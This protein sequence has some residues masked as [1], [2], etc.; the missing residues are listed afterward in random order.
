M[1]KGLKYWGKK[2]HNIWS[3]YILTYCQ[4]ND[5]VLDV[6]AGSGV[7]ALEAVQIGRRAISIDLNPMSK[8]IVE[9][10]VSDFN[11]ELFIKEGNEVCNKVYNYLKEIDQYSTECVNCSTIC[12][13]INYKWEKNEVYEIGYTCDVCKNNLTKE[14]SKNDIKKCKEI[15]NIKISNWFPDKD[16]PL[17][18]A[19]TRSFRIQTENKYKNIWTHRNLAIQ[20]FLFSEV[21]KVQDKATMT[22]LLFA[23]TSSLH[24][25][26]K[27]CV[28]R[29]EDAKRPFSTSWGRSAFIMASRQMEMNP[30]VTFQR[31][32]FERQGV[33]SVKKSTRDKFEGKVKIA[34]SVDQFF[35]DNT[36]N[37]LLL[38]ADASQIDKIIPKLS[39]DFVLTDPPYG[40]LVQYLSLSS[41]W[42][43]WLE[44]IDKNFEMDFMSEVTIN[45][46]NNF[47]SYHRML[48]KIFKSVEKVLKNERKMVVTFHN[49]QVNIWNSLLRATDAAGFAMKK[50]IYQPNRRTGESNVANPYG[51]SASDFY[52]RFE[53]ANNSDSRNG[54][55]VNREQSQYARVVIDAAKQ[56]ILERG[57]PTDLAFLMNG[58][59]VQ[60]AQHGHFLEGT[61]ED[62]TQILEQEKDNTFIVYP[63]TDKRLGGKWWINSRVQ[64][65]PNLPLSERLE[66]A[67]IQKLKR[68]I[69]VSY[70][71]ILAEIFQT[72]PNGLTP[73]AKDVRDILDEYGFQDKK[74]KKWRLKPSFD[75]NETQHSI[76]IGKIAKIGINSG[77][78]I[79]IGQREQSDIFNGQPLRNLINNQ[80][81]FLG[82][83][84]VALRRL[85]M[86]DLIFLDQ[87]NIK[88]VIEIENSTSITSAL[89]RASH[90]SEDVLRLIVIPDER[91]NFM[92]RK[93][94]EP[95]FAEYYE[96]GRWNTLT[97]SEVDKIVNN[98]GNKSI[99]KNELLKELSHGKR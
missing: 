63:E 62:I 80:K 88:A 45:D 64:N 52:L 3:K 32:C 51:T 59:Y 69:S 19:F 79:W 86:I 10:L 60:L 29:R 14:P 91:L 7:C 46:S 39:V 77:F 61:L 94:L 25:T 16:L 81:P 57:E 49:D 78:D 15:N 20:A 44:K 42:T 90:I 97:Y 1:Y 18:S 33:L 58:I 54:N 36:Y 87:N 85:K 8:F 30:L 31:S 68:E 93:M 55:N 37:L 98:L 43:V 28:P 48:T 40:G 2:P 22:A 56:V 72:F 65:Y 38:T 27:M 26:T 66:T 67:I 76:F 6:F 53:K 73:A 75:L 4:Q 92:K 83:D 17:G 95:L 47:E 74:N 99:S 41:L 70:D 23:F 71:E 35:H 50:I 21:C 96:R 5:I 24:L 11:E 82:I 12:L 34:K 84:E 89:E 9:F 13:V